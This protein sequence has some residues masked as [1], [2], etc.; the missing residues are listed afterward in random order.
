MRTL[1]IESARKHNSVSGVLNV[2]FGLIQHVASPV[3][4]L[5]SE[6]EDILAK[7]RKSVD[8]GLLSAPPV[9][10]LVVYVHDDAHLNATHR[11]LQ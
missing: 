9:G 8:C 7:V 2:R 5:A 11:S 6:F 4:D 1:S 10:I 3:V